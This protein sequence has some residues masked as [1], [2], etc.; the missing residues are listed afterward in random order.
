MKTSTSFPA[1]I[2]NAALLVFC[3]L[4][5]GLAVNLVRPAPL[6]WTYDWTHH[7]ETRAH[8][9]GIPIVFLPEV[10][11]LVD[12]AAGGGGSDVT[13]L[14]ARAEEE[15]EAAHIP[16]ALHLPPEEID[17]VLP[18][19]PIALT[20]DAPLLAYCSSLTCDDALTL[21]LALRDR[22]FSNVRLYSGG[23]EE[24]LAYDNPT[25]PAASLPEVAP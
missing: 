8:E 23:F 13:I 19:L 24:W 12:A 7:V 15:Y 5:L 10:R 14:D 9:A 3:A 21:A 16:G 20:P 11:E 22:A 2:A 18:S 25:E 17:A 1:I 4:V 6:P